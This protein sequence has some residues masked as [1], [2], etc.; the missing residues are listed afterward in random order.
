MLTL[1]FAIAAFLLFFLF[2]VLSLAKSWPER[3]VYLFIFAALF[4]LG[5]IQ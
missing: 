5:V 1:S 3:F 2:V 4:Y